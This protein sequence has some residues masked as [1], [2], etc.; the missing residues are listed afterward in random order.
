MAP[1]EN[2]LDVSKGHDDGNNVG[3]LNL[4]KIF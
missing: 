4:V 2:I 3:I 1:N